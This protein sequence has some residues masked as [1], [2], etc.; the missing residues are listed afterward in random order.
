[1]VTR[2]GV[3]ATGDGVFDLVYFLFLIVLWR[4]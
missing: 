3:F 2:D 4:L 1:M